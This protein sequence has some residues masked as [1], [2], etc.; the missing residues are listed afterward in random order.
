DYV[1]P[2]AI[3]RGRSWLMLVMRVMVVGCQTCDRSISPECQR[4]L[5]PTSGPPRWIRVQGPC[6]TA[7]STGRLLWRSG[8]HRSGLDMHRAM[9]IVVACRFIADLNSS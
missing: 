5:I 6:A 3:S 8:A 7:E 9:C 4:V 1:N 2:A